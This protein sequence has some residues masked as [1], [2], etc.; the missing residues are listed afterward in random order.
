[1]V[2]GRG[3]I[4]VRLVRN[5]AGLSSG[6]LLHA[7]SNTFSCLIESIPVKLETSCTVILPINSEWPQAPH[8]YEENLLRVIKILFT[9]APAL[10]VVSL[11]AFYSDNSVWILLN[12]T[13]SFSVQFVFEKT[14]KK[15]KNTYAW[16]LSGDVNWCMEYLFWFI[17]HALP[18]LAST[19]PKFLVPLSVQFSKSINE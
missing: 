5:F 10:T 14:E 19:S 16:R 8:H 18:I 7:I 9:V 12:P 4:T 11:L 2:V 1:M 13:Y 17:N 6:A 3:S 15:Q